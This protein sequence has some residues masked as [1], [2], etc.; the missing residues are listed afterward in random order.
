MKLTADGKLPEDLTK[1]ITSTGTVFIKG[2]VSS[3]PQSGLTIGDVYYITSLNKI[4]TATSKTSGIISSPVE[5]M[6]YVLQTSHIFYYWNGQNMQPMN[7][8]GSRK[9]TDITEI[10]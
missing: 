6:L 8:I 7:Y 3:A 4:F 2:F 9:I 1:D 5:N 10:L